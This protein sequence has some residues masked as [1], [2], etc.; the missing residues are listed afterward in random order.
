MVSQSISE[1]GAQ[2]QVLDKV[3]HVFSHASA[4]ML[5]I[6]VRLILKEKLRDCCHSPFASYRKVRA[7]RS[8]GDIDSQR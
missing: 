3:S 8:L 2:T 5:L 1:E 6:A 7:K 4:R